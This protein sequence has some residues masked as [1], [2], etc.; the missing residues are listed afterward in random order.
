[1]EAAQKL[2]LFFD[3]SKPAWT[4]HLKVPSQSAQNKLLRPLSRSF[5]FPLLGIRFQMYPIYSQCMLYRMINAEPE[6]SQD[7][8][9]LGFYFTH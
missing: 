8:Q 2:L 7:F 6:K 3:A 9:L 1:M 5:Y 4:F